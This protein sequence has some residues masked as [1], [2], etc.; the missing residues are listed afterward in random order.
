M[1]TF[2]F[3]ASLVMGLVFS[4]FS[5]PVQADVEAV[6]VIDISAPR[7]NWL[8]QM[9]IDAARIGAT[10][11]V[12]V[13][14]ALGAAKDAICKRRYCDYS[15]EN[16]LC[17]AACNGHKETVQALIDAGADVNAKIDDVQSTVLHTMARTVLHRVY[18]PK[19]QAYSFASVTEIEKYREIVQMLLDVGAN[20]DARDKDGST[21]LIHSCYYAYG[22]LDRQS[23]AKVLL[24][25]GAD[26]N[27]KNN[28]DKSV[29]AYLVAVNPSKIYCGETAV[30]L[31]TVCNDLFQAF[32]DAGADVNQ[33]ICHGKETLLTLAVKKDAPVEVITALVKAGAAL[34]ATD[35]NGDTPLNLATANYATEIMQV[36]LDAQVDANVANKLGNTPLMTAYTV[37]PVYCYGKTQPKPEVLAR[38]LLAGGAS[39]HVQNELGHTALMC[40]AHRFSMINPQDCDMV[41]AFRVLMDA[42]SD[43]YC[44]G[45]DGQSAM[46]LIDKLLT[47]K[48]IMLFA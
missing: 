9:M 17:V 32:I 2:G 39:V 42:G 16:A 18:C 10:K 47:I 19:A 26:V 15:F 29:L 14:L 40:A 44:R 13:C 7:A 11:T 21:A 5:A 25:A 12:R 48:R 27:I 1:P 20:I 6:A 8:S 22:L 4:V 34:N 35:S 45:K 31:Q 41:A 28:D 46:D 38:M 37:Y 36:L 43:V 23:V 33:T 30:T 24:A 3:K